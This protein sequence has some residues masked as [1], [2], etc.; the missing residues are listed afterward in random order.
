MTA[1]KP[2]WYSL[3]GGGTLRDFINL[4]HLPYTLWHLSYV[5]IGVSL[6]PVI[7]LDRSVA[8]LV[9]FFL[10]LGIGAHAL[11]ETMGN[12]LQ[13]KLT[14]VQLYFI[15]FSSLAVASAIGLY[16]VFAVSPLIFPIVA[17]E[18]FFAISYNLEAFGKRFHN[19][20]VFALSWGAI[21]FLAGYFVNSLSVSFPVILLSAAISL[22]TFVQRTLSIQARSVR[23]SVP[24]RI[25][26]LKLSNGSEVAASE[27]DLIGPAEKS[28]KALSLM[29]VL[30]ALASILQRI[31]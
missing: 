6:A 25:V 10:G 31:L 29:I 4:T 16:Y 23:R 13:T 8:V 27:K 20:L 24:S 15:G 28:L 9:S 2:A 19:M 18:V 22:L 5:L 12:P 3:A 1:L 11:D 17:I 7:H 30:I 26:S 14:K 21:P